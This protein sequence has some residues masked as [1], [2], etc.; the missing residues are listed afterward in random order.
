MNTRVLIISIAV[1]AITMVGVMLMAYL[2]Y[3]P[4]IL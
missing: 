2:T 1:I 4:H 3:D